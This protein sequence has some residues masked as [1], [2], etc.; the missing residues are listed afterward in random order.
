MSGFVVDVGSVSLYFFSCF[1]RLKNVQ[2]EKIILYIN[3]LYI[4]YINI[5]YN[6]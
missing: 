3:L 1:P 6:I 5:I 2:I 4:L